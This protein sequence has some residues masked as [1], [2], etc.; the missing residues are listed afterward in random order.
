MLAD[1]V[2]DTAPLPVYWLVICVACVA[3]A[4]LGKRYRR[5]RALVLHESKRSGPSLGSRIVLEIGFVLLFGILTL[6]PSVP[7]TARITYV[8][9]AFPL[10]AYNIIGDVLRTRRERRVHR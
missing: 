6:S 7:S 10:A 8:C 1:L 3:I 9:V 5:K 2:L 4:F